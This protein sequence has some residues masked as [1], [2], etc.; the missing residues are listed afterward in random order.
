VQEDLQR[1]PT[2]AAARERLAALA[3]EEVVAA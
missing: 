1:A 2:L 3:A